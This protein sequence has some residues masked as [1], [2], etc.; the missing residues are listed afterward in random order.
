M[1]YSLSHWWKR[2]DVAGQ[3]FYSNSIQDM[4]HHHS[5]IFPINFVTIVF[6]FV[7]NS[8]VYSIIANIK[9]TPLLMIISTINITAIKIVIIS[10]I[11]GVISINMWSYMIII[12]STIIIIIVLLSRYL[13]FIQ[14]SPRIFQPPPPCPLFL[15]LKH[16]HR[17]HHHYHRCYHL[18][19]HIQYQVLFSQKFA[20][21]FNSSW[22]HAIILSLKPSRSLIEFKS[23][24]LSL[25]C[26]VSSAKE[27]INDEMKQRKTVQGQW[28]D[29]NHQQSSTIHS[30][31]PSSLYICIF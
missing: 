6:I 17:C 13:D 3:L 12:T 9:T 14:S 25:E 4:P 22:W 21:I 8:I 20:V 19:H 5:R 29:S 30:L 2:I 18:H 7:I 16:H 31:P 28:E 23:N 1:L 15:P 24:S 10:I 26:V 27:R 11:I